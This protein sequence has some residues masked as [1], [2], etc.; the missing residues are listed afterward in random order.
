VAGGVQEERL[1]RHAPDLTARGPRE[2]GRFVRGLSGHEQTMLEIL[3]IVLIVLLLF[4]G[5]GYFWRGR[6]I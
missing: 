4:G 5:G 3:L 6:R 1:G 2:C